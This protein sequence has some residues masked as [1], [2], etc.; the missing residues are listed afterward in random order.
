M[1]STL[2]AWGWRAY[3]RRDVETDEPPEVLIFCPACDEREF[4]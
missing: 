3:F 2:D 1:K 4:S